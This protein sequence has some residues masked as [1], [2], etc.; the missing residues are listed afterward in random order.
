ML[1]FLGE[2]RMPHDAL[3][4]EGELCHCARGGGNNLI[5]FHKKKAFIKGKLL[6][7]L[8]G[9]KISFMAKENDLVLCMKA[10]VFKWSN[11]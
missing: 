8:F 3:V 7:C 10:N 6:K 11:F 1:L 5:T 9:G 2:R 4:G